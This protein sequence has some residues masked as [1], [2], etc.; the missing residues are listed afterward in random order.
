MLE[1]IVF[2]GDL[3]ADRGQGGAFPVNLGNQT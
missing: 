2:Y 1:T 3:A